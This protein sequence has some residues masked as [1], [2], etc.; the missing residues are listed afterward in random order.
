MD[1]RSCSRLRGNKADALCSLGWRGCGVGRSILLEPQEALSWGAIVLPTCRSLP[2]VY[3]EEMLSL[4]DF[5]VA[6]PK[7]RAEGKPR[8]VF[9]LN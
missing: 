5:Y 2:C 7:G 6:F 1:A 9:I 4:T 8:R 3:L